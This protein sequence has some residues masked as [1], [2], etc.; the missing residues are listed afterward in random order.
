M[1]IRHRLTE[2]EKDLFLEVVY[3]W[4]AAL[5]WDFSHLEK[6]RAEVAPPQ[7]IR[8]VPHSAWQAP[9]FIVPRALV[10]TVVDMLKERLA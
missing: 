5:A 1:K 9:G 4:E 6:V 8:I 3:N 10:P 7:E 2:Q